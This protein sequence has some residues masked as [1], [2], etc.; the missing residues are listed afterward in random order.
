[1]VDIFEPVRV[2]DILLP[3]RIVMSPMTRARAGLTGEPTDVMVEYYAQRASSGL[4][5]S[6]GVY[7]YVE[8][9]GYF[10]TPGIE[11]DRQIEGWR[12]VT[13]AVHT[14]GGRIV[15]QLMHCGRVGH[16]LNKP[17]GA[18]H[19]A[20]SAIG[21]DASIFVADGSMQRMTAP[22]ALSTAE[23]VA[24]LDGFGRAA[25]AAVQAGFDGVELH[26]ASG[27]LPHQFLS[28]NTNRRDDRY[29]GT[30]ERRARFVVEAV[31]RI[32]AAVGAGRT[33][34]KLAP[35]LT[36]NDIHDETVAET[37][38]HLLKSID[39]MGLA[40]LHFQTVLPPERGAGTSD[41]RH[42]APYAFMRA[43]FSGV[44]MA[45]GDLDVDLANLAV[46][47]GHADLVAFGRPYISNPDLKERLERGLALAEPDRSTFYG[48]GQQG[49]TD[50]PALAG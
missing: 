38:G 4:I 3:N 47:G 31:E 49:Y 40:Y 6:E 29:G 30:P 8:G 21:A 20:P 7:P 50:Y 18:D 34:L 33:A 16:A 45:A 43:H 25:A 36:Y 24:R 46:Q 22:R 13:D 23:V 17:E 41:L 28:S 19:V 37:Y 14:H 12:R 32:A 15:M 11:T 42:C 35:G 44:L 2:G 48:G 10:A 9:K 26:A 1:M 5:I 39:G 27:Y